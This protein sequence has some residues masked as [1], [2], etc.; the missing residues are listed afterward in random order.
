MSHERKSSAASFLQRLEFGDLLIYLYILGLSRQY[1][2]IVENNIVAW[3]L[4]LGLSLVATYFYITTKKLF[5]EKSGP[6]F[7][8]LV[9]LPLLLAYLFRAAFPDQ[10]Y[11]VLNY[12]LLHAERTLRGPLYALGDFFPTALP[13]NPVAD[14]LTGITRLFFGFR[15]GTVINLLALLWTAQIVDRILRRFLRPTWL[16]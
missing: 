9:G 3:I 13:F 8:I 7:W 4:S 5:P 16:R 10:S 15:L 14:T 6:V 12:R 2:W 11:D 1:L